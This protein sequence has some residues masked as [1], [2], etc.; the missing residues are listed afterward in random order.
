MTFESRYRDV[1]AVVTAVA[2]FVLAA[3]GLTGSSRA[4]PP[5]SAG[6]GSE[7]RVHGPTALVVTPPTRST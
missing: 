3:A 1:I 4:Q 2:E 5:A 7:D 6:F